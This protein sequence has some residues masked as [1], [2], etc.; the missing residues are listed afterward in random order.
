MPKV[1]MYLKTTCPYCVRAAALLAQ[2]G[3]QAKEY[4]VDGGGPLKDEMVQ[5][6]GRITVPQIFINDRHVGGCDDLFAL[7]RQGKLDQLLAA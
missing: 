2:K 1:E 4:N 7:E 6:S 3:V 5:R